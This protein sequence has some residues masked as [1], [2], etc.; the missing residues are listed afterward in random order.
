MI[1]PGR[2]RHDKGEE[3]EVIGRAGHSET[4][5]EFV[6]SRVLYGDRGLWARPERCFSRRCRWTDGRFRGFS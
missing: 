1:K 5:E 2:Y 3:Y 4:G 6:V